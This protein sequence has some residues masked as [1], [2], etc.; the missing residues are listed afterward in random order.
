MLFVARTPSTIAHDLR[1]VVNVVR[2]S[3]DFARGKL[4]P[5][6]PAA[7]DIA[8]IA[9]ACE[10]A[11][12]LTSELRAMTHPKPVRP[13]KRATRSAMPEVVRTRE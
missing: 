10:E 11:A 6:H 2:G 9:C 7:S 4:D 13:P 8:R 1:G 5:N 3:A 12:A